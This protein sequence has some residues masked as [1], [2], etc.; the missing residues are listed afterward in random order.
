[1]RIPSANEILTAVL[2]L[3]AVT[4]TSLVVRR[5]LFLASSP[6][7]TQRATFVP[8]WRRALAKGVTL[9]SQNAPVQLIEFADFQCPYCRSF[10]RVLQSVQQRF[11]GKVALTF[12]HLP[13]EVHEFAE[14]AA[15]AAECA[16]DQGRFQQMY[17]Y[18]FQHPESVKEFQSVQLAQ[19]A[20]VPDVPRFEACTRNDAQLP[21]IVE[22]KQLAQAFTVRGT[23]TL[24]INGWKLTAPPTAS[25][26]NQMVDAVLQGKPPVS[27]ATDE[28]DDRS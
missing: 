5:E 13:L 8:E 24:L 21:R 10:Y 11:P 19:A 6:A 26:L 9:G 23:P 16:G 28:S 15:R 27:G 22:G 14:A 3:C 4:T 1:V 7:A 2:V 17:D 20:K 18:L 12:I 25:E